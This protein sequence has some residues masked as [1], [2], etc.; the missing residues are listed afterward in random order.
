MLWDKTQDDVFWS[1]KDS[2]FV[3]TGYRG[4]G[5]G[6]INSYKNYLNSIIDRDASKL[7]FLKT[8]LTPYGDSYYED[9]DPYSLA[10]KWHPTL[11]QLIV[12]DWRNK[13]LNIVAIDF[14]GIDNIAKR[15]VLSNR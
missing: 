12:Y 10:K 11:E 7:T 15:V 6:N 1:Y 14:I 4:S 13:S 8:E 2:W 3:E 9:Q 5:D